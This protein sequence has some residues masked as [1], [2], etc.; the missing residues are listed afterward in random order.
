MSPL[1]R[2]NGGFTLVEVTI[3]AVVATIAA[4]SFAA[5]TASQRAVNAA[6]VVYQRSGRVRR[7]APS[8]T[9]TTFAGSAMA[10]RCVHVDI[11]GRL[12]I[13]TC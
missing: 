8:F 12:V 10:K 1:W 2:T 6:S 9:L 4:P 5:F 11:N 7:T 13:Q 3:V